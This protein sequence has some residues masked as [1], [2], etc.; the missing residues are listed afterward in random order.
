[1]LIAV[2]KEICKKRYYFKHKDNF[3]T[4]TETEL[5]S[6]ESESEGDLCPGSHYLSPH[7]QRQPI[8]EFENERE[9]M[10]HHQI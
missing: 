8:E 6:M 1:M 4:E 5:V 2:I 10:V 9:R 3:D 7:S